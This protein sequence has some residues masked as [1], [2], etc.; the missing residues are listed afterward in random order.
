VTAPRT[1]ADPPLDPPGDAPADA[2]AETTPETPDDGDDAGGAPITGTARIGVYTDTDRTR[3]YRLVT[4][5]AHAWG[6]HWAGNASV[7]IDVVS[8]ASLD[9]RTSPL[10]NVDVVTTASGR[11]RED[12]GSMSDRRIQASGGGSWTDGSG[13]TVSSTV[14]VAKEHDY[15]SVSAGL[16]G[17]YDVLGRTTTLLG[18]VTV[19][20][21]WISS[22]L[23]DTL[24]KNLTSVGWSFGVARVLT[25]RDAIRVRYDGEL[26][27]GYHASPYRNVRFGNWMTTTNEETGQIS[28]TNTIGSVDGLPETEP[29]RR[30][31]HAA[32]LELVHSL[33]P[34]VG[35]HAALRGTHDS[36]GVNS[37]TP[38]LDLRIAKPRWRAQLGYRFYLQTRAD[39]FADKYTMDPSAYTYFSSDKDLGDERGHVVRLSAAYVLL[40]S[41]SMT[42]SRLLLDF[43]LELAHYNY[44]GFTLL[45][46]RDSVFALIGLSLEL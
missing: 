19:T 35:L 22:V 18:G 31:K 9:V 11:L 8:S 3:I 2:P 24:A 42:D 44:P 29:E 34:D 7:D 30:L 5:I 32:T 45:P 41:E 10:G 28:F 12:G 46:S 15:F 38:S 25:P 14:S 17:Q 1:H 43:Q 4:S 37:L 23:D 26:S 21:N 39:F 40:D 20:R 13:H 33:A 36:W 16:N 6:D 27:D